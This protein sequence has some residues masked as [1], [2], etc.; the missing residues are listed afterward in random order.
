QKAAE[1]LRKNKYRNSLLISGY[2]T[3]VHSLFS[4]THTKRYRAFR[5][6]LF[7]TGLAHLMGELA[8]ETSIEFIAVGGDVHHFLG[9][10]SVSEPPMVYAFLLLYVCFR[11]RRR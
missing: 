4:I 2:F 8:E 10:E 3:T 5:L 11:G 1:G 7:F 9:V 6:F